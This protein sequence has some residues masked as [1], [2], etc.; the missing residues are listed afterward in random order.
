MTRQI[1]F[2]ITLGITLSVFAFTATRIIGYFRLTRK[3]FPVRDIGR[4]FLEVF[5][6]AIGQ[7]KIFRRPVTGT[8]HAMVFWGFCVILFGSL[9]MVADG[10]AGTEQSLKFL[11]PVYDLITAS[12]DIFA[13]II[14][15]AIIAFLVRRIFLHIRRFEGIEMKKISHLDANIALTIILLLMISLLGLNT[16]NLSYSGAEGT[17]LQGLYPVSSLLVSLFAGLT[18]DGI[19]TW[20]EIFWWTHILLI[21]IF[22]NLLPYSKHFHVFMSV[23]NVFL[24][25][26]EPLGKLTTMESIT[27][28]VKLMMDPNTAFSQPAA[29][30]P[31]ER[32]GV[33]DAED[34]T[35]K[36]YFDSLA[37]TECGR[38]TSVCPANIT[39]KRLSPRKIMMDLRARMKEKGPGMLKEGRAYA[40]ARSLVRDYITE[41][42]LWA[43]TTCNACAMECPININQPTLIVDMRRYLVMEEGSAPG[44]L[45]AMFSN[46]ENNGAPWQYPAEDRLQWSDGHVPVMADLHD[47]GKEPEYLFWVGCAG[48]YDDR[49]KKVVRAF[50]KILNHLGTSFAVLGREESCSGDPARRAGNEMLYQMQAMQ[51]I[52]ILKRYGVTKILTICPHCYNIFRNE[53]P[54]LGGNYEVVNYVH[55]IDR[56][57]AEGKLAVSDRLLKDATVTYHDPCYLGRANDIYAEPRSILKKLSPGF[58]EMGRNRSFALC[59]GAG[60]AQMFKEAEQG[61]KEVFIER[62]EEALATGASVIATSCPFCMT[63]ITDG[64]KYKNKEQEVKNYDIAELIAQSLDL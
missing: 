11:G 61:T 12:G 25:R 59:C 23:P 54:D 32:F 38:C 47:K 51:N 24:T 45:K 44:G 6:V 53:Y 50:I 20:R 64:I 16:A 37:C 46:V 49:Y 30:A 63:M 31:V 10:L 27:R 2:A 4:R 14:T 5:K 48:A 18:L 35:W 29:D 7:T 9:E 22:A 43:C 41:E 8:M 42:E 60:G 56:A 57:I 15:V 28:E 52:D 1:I 21:F 17:E 62:T 33:R 36:N 26:L 55:F 3:G 19:H 39:G 13:L 34:A 58:T 40:D